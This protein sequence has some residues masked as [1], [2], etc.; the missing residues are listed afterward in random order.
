MLASNAP[1]AIQ[2]QMLDVVVLQQLTSQLKRLFCS[3]TH[4][5]FLFLP[6]SALRIPLVFTKIDAVGE[7]WGAQYG[8]EALRIGKRGE[9]IRRGCHKREAGGGGAAGVEK[10]SGG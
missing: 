5:A 10:E 2:I 9:I 7:L 8:F 1:I 4:E 6:L 3:H